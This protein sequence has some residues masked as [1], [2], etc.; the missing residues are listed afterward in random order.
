MDARSNTPEALRRV[1][2][3]NGC[4]AMSIC[5]ARR[6]TRYLNMEQRAAIYYFAGIELQMRVIESRTPA[7]APS[8]MIR[9]TQSVIHLWD[10][11]ARCIRIV[12][13]HLLN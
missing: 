6:S 2:Y 3:I 12:P 13:K 1:L 4:T 10:S 11:E 9:P 8:I 5:L 7:N